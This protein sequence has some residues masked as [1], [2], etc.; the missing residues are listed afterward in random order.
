MCTIDL[1]SEF[2]LP[3]VSVSNYHFILNVSD[4][5][6]LLEFIF[7]AEKLFF[8]FFKYQTVFGC[9][10]KGVMGTLALQKVTSAK[11]CR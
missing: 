4:L 5:Q 1:R 2:N 3:V 7:K 8:F 6:K 10:V 11:V 9:D